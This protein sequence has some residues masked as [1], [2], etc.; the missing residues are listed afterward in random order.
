MPQSWRRRSHKYQNKLAAKQLMPSEEFLENTTVPHT[1]PQE[2]L[3]SGLE[4]SIPV[5]CDA[6]VEETT[7]D[8]GHASLYKFEAVILQ[9]E[10]QQ[11]AFL[12]TRIRTQDTQRAQSGLLRSLQKLRFSC[13]I[14]VKPM[15]GSYNILFPIRF[16]DRVQW[17]LKLP[18]NG[19]SGQWDEKSAEALSSEA[20][21]MKF[22]YHNSSVPVPR[23]YTFDPT[24]DNPVKCP[25]ILMEQISGKNLFYEWH[26]GK[27]RAGQ[28]RFRERALVNIAGAMVQLSTFT[29]SSAGALRFD[30]EGRADIGPYSKVDHFAAYSRSRSAQ[31]PTTTFSQH[32]PFSNPKDYFL[33]SLDKEDPSTLPPQ[34]QGQRLL[35]RLLVD[36]F[37]RATEG[38]SSESSAG[39]VLAHPDFNLQNLVVGRDGTLRGLIDWDGVAVVPRCLGYDEYPLWLTSD[40]DPHYWNYDAEKKR[41]RDPDRPVMMA[42]DLERYR[43]VYVRAIEDASGGRRSPSTRLSG[44]ARSLY[45]AANEPLSLQ[46]NVANIFEKI[47]DLTTEDQY[48]DQAAEIGSK[49][50]IDVPECSKFT[51]DGIEI[52]EIL[53]DL[54][55]QACEEEVHLFPLQIQGGQGFTSALTAGRLQSASRGDNEAV[56]AASFT[57]LSTKSYNRVEVDDEPTSHD[58]V[59]GSRSRRRPYDQVYASAQ[60]PG[61]L[62]I[63]LWTACYHSLVF[64]A[65]LV[66]LMSRLRSFKMSPL[67]FISAGFLFSDTPILSNSVAILLGG[68]FFTWIMQEFLGQPDHKGVNSSSK[69]P[70]T[71]C[72]IRHCFL[73]GSAQAQ[74]TQHQ[75]L[76]TSITS[77]DS[78]LEGAKEDGLVNSDK[79][80]QEEAVTTGAHA[81]ANRRFE[82]PELFPNAGGP[83]SPNSSRSSN[84]DSPSKSNDSAS[85]HT[86]ISIHSIYE[87]SD[88][89]SSS[90]S[91]SPSSS[92]IFINI[93]DVVAM[94][95]KK[96]QED[97]THDFGHFTQRNVYNA[98][99]NTGTLDE[100]RMRRLKIGFQRLLASLDDRFADFDGLML[101]DG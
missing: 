28:A 77:L 26:Y 98:F 33:A 30:P 34:Q 40:W 62:L 61:K 100:S 87:G 101:R 99:H 96:W 94:I 64:S 74:M 11:A 22:I 75:C 83:A 79:L 7:S 66:L 12:A 27:S 15:Y 25:Y 38:M 23:I 67:I 36:W 78:A 60:W 43:A 17:L 80:L 53:D 56:T 1:S 82:F 44:L 55:D 8:G 41:V 13:K 9:A 2:A 70:S 76:K 95:K 37:F 10:I 47:A 71:S 89:L 63:W 50:S 6:A 21:T 81:P 14:I 59:A 92:S 93:D 48:D 57:E 20:L 42:A 24:P 72:C 39:F 52:P 91:S 68:L 16:K 19:C 54:E 32:G 88:S 5:G 73:E 31:E 69:G 45:I 35:L 85:T 29:F 65:T 58:T 84:E 49:K 3:Q 97:P 46:D 18:A 4:T 90:S 86:N 51:S